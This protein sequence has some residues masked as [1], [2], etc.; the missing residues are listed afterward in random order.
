MGESMCQDVRSIKQD[1]MAKGSSA[2]NK[3]GDNA[4]G[5]EG[6]SLTLVLL[7]GHLK[8]V[9]LCLHICEV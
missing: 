3:F 6:C 9:L 8:M 4:F 7:E 2:M 5:C 1:M